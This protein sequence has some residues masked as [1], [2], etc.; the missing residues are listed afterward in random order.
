MSSLFPIA[1]ISAVVI[2][3]LLKIYF[4][5]NRAK[6]EPLPTNVV[7]LHQFNA[8][9]PLPSCSPFVMKLETYLRMAKIK[10]CNDFS[11]TFGKRKGKIPWIELN[12]EE[13]EDTNFIMDHLNEFFQVDLDKDLSDEDRAK[14]HALKRM[15]EENTRWASITN[16][17]F[18]NSAHISH[19]LK[20]ANL[21]S[22]LYLIFRYVLAGKVHKDMKKHG[23]GRHSTEEIQSIAIGDLKAVSAVLGHKKYMFGDQPSTIDAAMFG[24]ISNIIYG[25]PPESS[26]TLYVKDYLPNLNS[27][28]ER[29]KSNFWPDWEQRC[30]H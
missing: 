19:T 17:R 4:G 14:A 10:Y 9:R 16:V 26:L 20:A 8:C 12:G 25:N 3:L 13:I 7:R 30:V 24:I 1:I 6:R 21:P 28:V 27:Y 11:M 5:N 15:M 29:I 18:Q 2:V 22:Y 23:I